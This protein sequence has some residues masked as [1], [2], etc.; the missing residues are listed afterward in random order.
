MA[1][2]GTWQT[3]TIA[4]NLVRI[5]EAPLSVVTFQ[6]QAAQSGTISLYG[7]GGDIELPERFSVN[8]D[9]YANVDLVEAIQV[10]WN[11]ASAIGVMPALWVTKQLSPFLI[12]LTNGGLGDSGRLELYVE[13]H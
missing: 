2:I 4:D 12:T 3:E 8:A 10:R 11:I 1:F 6:L 13:Y 9:P 7:G 5:S